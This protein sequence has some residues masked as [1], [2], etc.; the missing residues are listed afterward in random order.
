MVL[1]ACEIKASTHG[2]FF[3]LK[4]ISENACLLETQEKFVDLLW[5]FCKYLQRCKVIFSNYLLFTKHFLTCYKKK[6]ILENDHRFHYEYIFAFIVIVRFLHEL[7]QYVASQYWIE[8]NV[9]L[10]SYS[11]RIEVRNCRRTLFTFEHTALLFW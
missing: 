9:R 11:T 5:Q 4:W 7:K 8:N 10:I 3:L 2:G 6:K 1:L